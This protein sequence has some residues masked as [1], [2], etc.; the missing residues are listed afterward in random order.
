MANTVCEQ[1]GGDLPILARRHARFCSGRCRVAAHRARRAATGLPK[2]LTER[3][4][5]V[6][7]DVRKAPRTLDGGFASVVSPSTWAEH[8][9]AASSSVGVGMGYV[10]AEGDGVVVV[11]L[12]H[13][14][15]GGELA[16]WAR[17]ILDRCPPTF[18]EVSQSGDGLH[19][20][21][22]G[23]VERGRRLRRDGAAVE[24]Y[25]QGRYVA[26]TGR[27]F[28]GAPV[29]LADISVVVADLI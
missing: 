15:D 29:R 7:R 18:V 25:G 4:R 1:C 2:E 17:E 10:L 26:V 8:A 12:D 22:H 13:C 3:R 28:E 24:V 16:P 9:D 19:I 20:F 11:D 23:R 14:L 27:R 21:G 6:R 5:W